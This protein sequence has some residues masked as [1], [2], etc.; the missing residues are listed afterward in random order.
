MGMELGFSMEKNLFSNLGK[1]KPTEFQTSLENFTTQAL[2]YL[3]NVHEQFR[4]KFLERIEFES[5]VD[6]KIIT[7]KKSGNI[8]PDIS[9]FNEDKKIICLIENKVNSP[10]YVRQIDNYKL[11]L[12]NKY[13]EFQGRIV[14]ITRYKYSDNKSEYIS[15]TWNDIYNI[16]DKVIKGK[17]KNSND[18][19][20]LL[21]E[22]K[23]YLKLEGIAKMYNK[24]EFNLPDPKNLGLFLLDCFNESVNGLGNIKYNSDINF[25]GIDIFL[26][27]SKLFCGLYY[28]RKYYQG[29]IVFEFYG[30][31]YQED[32]KRNFEQYNQQF[33]KLL[34]FDLIV[35]EQNE[36]S[37]KQKISAYIQNNI[38]PII[39]CEK[40]MSKDDFKSLL[41][42]EN[43]GNDKS[44][45]VDSLEYIKYE[46]LK[47]FIYDKIIIEG[48]HNKDDLKP[49]FIN[50]YLGFEFFKNSFKKWLGFKRN[51]LIE[52]WEYDERDFDKFIHFFKDYPIEKNENSI[53][54]KIDNFENLDV[55]L[56]YLNTNF[57]K[58]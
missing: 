55:V 6:L 56:K 21:N 7:Q 16:C 36:E 2:A 57:N 45:Y 25:G 42:K 46:E 15:L 29:K 1:Y 52:F 13:S 48:L 33:H 54:S 30:E 32:A 28:G 39:I 10:Y 35:S 22:F 58:R 41:K 8:I 9:I 20:F 50:E 27:D 11:L 40:L 23:E 47:S 26:G 5:D 38:L 37:Q 34:N 51:E 12:V 44:K 4:K 53:Y 3:L 19:C 17:N 18:T 24:I 43:I 14:S 49:N 31:L